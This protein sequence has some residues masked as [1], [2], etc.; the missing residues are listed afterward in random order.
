MIVA[1]DDKTVGF[2]LVARLCYLVLFVDNECFITAGTLVVM[3]FAPKELKY[4]A[5]VG[6]SIVQA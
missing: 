2:S 4:F 1:P 5:V 3:D 6:L